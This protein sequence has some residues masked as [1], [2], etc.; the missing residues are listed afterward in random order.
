MKTLK[1]LV[2]AATLFVIVASSAS[3]LNAQEYTTDTGGYGYEQGR[4]APSIAPAVALGAIA[5]AAIIAIAVQNDNHHHS[6][7]HNVHSSN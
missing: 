3:S 1:R 5:L 4:R 2:A 6:H 7:G